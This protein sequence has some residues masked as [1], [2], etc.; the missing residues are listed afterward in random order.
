MAR[1]DQVEPH[2]GIVRAELAANLTL[3]GTGEFGPQGVSLDANGR[4]VVGVAGQSGI[5]GVLVKNAPK[6]PAGLATT[7]TVINN[8][9]GA[10]AGDRVDIMTRGQILDCTG[11]PAGSKIY[12]AAGGVLSTTVNAGFQVGYTVEAARLVVV[13]GLG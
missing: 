8:W 10:R 7:A 2:V 6:M 11:L 4:C 5:A 3:S 9:M 12:S 13:L 1:Y